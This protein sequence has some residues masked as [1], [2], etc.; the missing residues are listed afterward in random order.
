MPAIC[1]QECLIYIFKH[2]ETFKEK[3]TTTYDTRTTRL[4]YPIHK[5]SL[6]EKGPV[7]SCIRYYTNIQDTYQDCIFFDR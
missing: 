1:I 4:K 7:Y 3:T 2:K 5:K 6:V